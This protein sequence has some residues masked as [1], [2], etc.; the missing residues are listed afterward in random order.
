MHKNQ[1]I[2]IKDNE[3]FVKYCRPQ[4]GAIN[5]GT[6]VKIDSSMPKSIRVLRI[7]PIWNSDEEFNQANQNRKQTISLLNAEILKPFFFC[8]LMC[9]LEKGETLKIAGK[10]FFVNDC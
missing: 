8:G 6:E 3:F 10:E 1:V 7:A 4:F 2:E 9:Y 5:N